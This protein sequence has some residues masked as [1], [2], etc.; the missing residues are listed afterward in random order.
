MNDLYL[1]FRRFFSNYNRMKNM[2]FIVC[3]VMAGAMT[4]FANNIAITNVSITGQDYTGH[5]CLIQFDLSWD[6]SW[7]TSSVPQNWDATWVFVK[8]R[9]VGGNWQ[10]ATLNTSGHTAPSGSTISPA[11]D[12]TGAFIYRSADGNGS[13]TWTGVQLRWNYGTDGVADDAAVEVQVFG[14]EMVYI[15]SGAFWLGDGNGTTASAGAFEGSSTNQ[16]FLYSSSHQIKANNGAINGD[17][18]YIRGTDGSVTL[19]DPIGL[20][21]EPNIGSTYYNYSY[22]TGR[23]PFYLMKYEISQEQYMTFLNALTR[24]QQAS[25]VG[26]N[27]SGTSVTNRYVLSNTSGMNY[28][29]GIRCDATI[30]ASPTPVTFYCDYNGNGTGNEAGD[31]QNIACNYL[32]YMDLAAYLDWAGLRLLTEVE[33]EKASRGPNTPVLGEYAWGTTTIHGSSYTLTNP[34]TAAEAISDMGTNTGNACYAATSGLFFGPAR[35]GIFAASSVN[36]TRIETGASYYGVMELSGNVLERC[37]HIGSVAGRS[38]TGLHGN[39]ALNTAGAADVN[40]WPGINGNTTYSTANGVYGGTTGVT[41]YAGIGF[42]GGN[43]IFNAN[44]FSTSRRA[45]A[46]QAGSGTIRDGMYGGRGC[47]T[48]P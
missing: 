32:N 42:N 14:I 22:P 6:N 4:G 38:Y 12:G 16:S 9:T 21:V 25:R 43:W 47:R 31:G 17:D 24:S 28:R 20:R 11:S 26:T 2:I 10:H 7:R 29:Q 3:L 44:E 33:F 13:N 19:L 46:G 27:I 36:H 23:N 35:C 37:V 39:G 15:P 45:S 18:N 48:A 5:Y 40:Y 34:G 1:I 30:P 41:G 8:Y